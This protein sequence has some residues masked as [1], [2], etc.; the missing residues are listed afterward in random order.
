MVDLRF[1]TPGKAPREPQSILKRP[2]SSAQYNNVR[3][4]HELNNRAYSSLVNQEDLLIQLGNSA[5]FRT[6]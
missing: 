2:I 4:S 1:T 6:I 3:A 5:H